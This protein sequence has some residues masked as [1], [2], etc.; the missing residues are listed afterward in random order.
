LALIVIFSFTRLLVASWNN[1][2]NCTWYCTWIPG[3]DRWGLCFHSVGWPWVC[4]YGQNLGTDL[5][6]NQ[7]VGARQLS[8]ELYHRGTPLWNKFSGRLFNRTIVRISYPSAVNWNK[9]A[10]EAYACHCPEWKAL[11]CDTTVRTDPTLWKSSARFHCSLDSPVSFRHVCF[12]ILKKVFAYYLGNFPIRKQRLSNSCASAL[13]QTKFLQIEFAPEYH[14][15]SNNTISL[16]QDVIPLDDH[17][18]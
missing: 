12:Q 10:K 5:R 9:M 3:A 15:T 8:K 2:K 13:S 11:K 17:K 4:T 18:K 1:N 14:R 6:P 16:G 7:E